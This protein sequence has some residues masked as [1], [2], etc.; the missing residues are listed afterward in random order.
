[1]ARRLTSVVTFLLARQ[2]L[3]SSAINL[4]S[5][6]HQLMQSTTNLYT[7]FS[8]SKLSVQNLTSQKWCE[9]IIHSSFRILS[10]LEPTCSIY[11][12][13]IFSIAKS[14]SMRKLL[15]RDWHPSG[16]LLWKSN[17]VPKIFNADPG[18]KCRSTAIRNPLFFTRRTLKAGLILGAIRIFITRYS[19]AISV[20]FQ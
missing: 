15:F 13:S 5:L 17:E 8:L 9:R 19:G 20:N 18:D 1:M 4:A 6:D 10:G 14:K 16:L 3:L 2:S 11:L 12:T 7:I